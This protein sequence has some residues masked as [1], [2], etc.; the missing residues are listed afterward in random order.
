MLFE[1]LLKLAKYEFVLLFLKV[2]IDNIVIN[3][4]LNSEIDFDSLNLN[5]NSKNDAVE[6]KKIKI[7]RNSLCHCKSGKKYKYC[8]GKEF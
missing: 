3:D 6:K 2:P 7:G 4:E 8:H 1:E 5:H